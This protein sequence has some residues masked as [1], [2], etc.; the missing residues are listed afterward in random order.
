MEFKSFYSGSSGNLYQVKTEKG[1]LLIDPGVP[2]SKIKKALGFNLSSVS[3][4]L[5]SHSHG[6]HSKAVHDIAR[7]GIDC[8]MTAQTAQALK[9]NGHR[10]QIIEPRKQTELNGVTILPFQTEHDCDGSVGFLVSDGKEK[11]LYATDTF[12][13]RYKFK[14]LTIIAIECN[15]SKE[16]LAPDLDPTRKKRLYSSHMSLENAIRFFKAND[17]SKIREI[18]LLHLSRE[19]SDPEMFKRKIQECTG[20]PVFIGGKN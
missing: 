2:I 1:N 20:K 8:L 15:Y 14:G 5:V 3:A 16:T 12:F 7:A 6:D 19:N 10:T 17:L 18:H 11:L 4:A 13:I 9:M